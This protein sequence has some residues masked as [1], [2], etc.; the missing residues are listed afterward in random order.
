MAAINAKNA[1]NLLTK[2]Q[3][4]SIEVAEASLNPVERFETV[5]Q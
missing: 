4:L 1:L 2:A 5:T 3:V